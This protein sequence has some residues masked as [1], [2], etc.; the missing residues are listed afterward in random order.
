MEST[1]MFENGSGSHQI[2]QESKKLW[3]FL[4]A[5]SASI[6]AVGAGTALAWTS[7][8]LP[9]LQDK[10]NDILFINEEEA[11]W[12]GAFLPVGAIV[13]A[14]PA[15]TIADKLGRK[16]ALLLLALPFI[17]SWM[18]IVLVNAVW[19]LYTARFLVGA[20]VGAVCVIVPT[21]I[22]EISSPSTRGSL[23]AM[24][25][26]FL[27]SGIVLTFI[28]GTIASYRI[29]GIVCGI[30]EIIF[31]ATFIFMPE[32]P[33]WLV[34]E[35]RKPEATMA[36]KIFRGNNYNLT[37]EISEMQE[38]AEK[39]A[40]KKSSI[41]D[42]I[43]TAGRRRAILASLGCMIFQQLSGINA[44]V[45]Y[46]V[47]I[48]KAAKMDDFAGPAAIAVAFV[49]VIMAGVAALIVD[50]AGRKPLLIVSSTLMA[51]SLTALGYFFKLS[52][53][54]EDTSSISWLPLVSLVLFMIAFSVGLGP[55][56]WMLTGELF[57]SD[58]KA[59]ASSL[60]VMVN[61]FLVFLVTKTFASMKD[62]L[63]SAVTFWIF[64]G[65][66]VVATFF[67]YFIVPETKGK[68]LEQIQNELN[69]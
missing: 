67:E 60:A 4:A 40:S 63:G 39:T 24:F 48:F 23:G 8:V 28:L 20:A 11:S 13:G 51:I 29:I 9:I 26:L 69:H 25:Q 12:I 15:G 22:A 54:K 44:V 16:K 52:D 2:S 64:A 19:M 42:L 21:Y 41:F 7:P 50:K 36:L 47:Q 68:T 59:V 33:S 43:R 37:N 32:S 46:T 34:S 14:L 38:E 58:I 31:V 1:G 30:I 3:Q 61:W 35:G 57:T 65:I 55:I 53:A 49:Q 66:M 56:P 62:S 10:N 5:C 45:F 17:L 18:L 27:A 6:L